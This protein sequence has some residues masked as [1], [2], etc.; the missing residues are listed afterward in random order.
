MRTVRLRAAVAALL[1][2]VCAAPADAQAPD[3]LDILFLGNSYVYYN[4]LADQLEGLSAALAGTYLR[5]AHHLHGGFTLRRHLD[6]GHVPAVLDG[7]APDGAPWDRVVIQG[8][9]RLG[10]PYA[11]EAAGTLGDPTAFASG[12]GEVIDMVEARGSSAMLYMTWAKEAFPA[13]IDALAAA[14]EGVGATRGV[15]VAPVGRAWERV[16]T[17]R[18]DLDLFTDDGSHPSPTGTYLTACVFYATL[19][20]RSPAGG[21]TRLS[22][23][24][25]QTPG[26]AASDRPVTLVALDAGTAGYLQRV[27]WEVVRERD[28]GG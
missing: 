6:D 18:P 13:Q 25:M 19:T 17:E 8:H 2:A 4:N 28:G 5:T 23:T 11:D 3:T 1:L 24:A 12:A 16:R 14:Y 27:A 26:V 22:G 7:P 21:P 10:V 20:G 15:P 9:S